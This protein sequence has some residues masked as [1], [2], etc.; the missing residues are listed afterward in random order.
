MYAWLLQH[1]RCIEF[2]LSS[3]H[4]ILRGLLQVYNIKEEYQDDRD[5]IAVLILKQPENLG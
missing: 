1:V 3:G 2:N 5:L 4:P